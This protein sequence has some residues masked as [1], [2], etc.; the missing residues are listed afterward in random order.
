M[1]TKLT[2]KTGRKI[3]LKNFGSVLENLIFKALKLDSLKS[4]LT[5]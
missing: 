4:D 2:K 3:D 5:F 1:F